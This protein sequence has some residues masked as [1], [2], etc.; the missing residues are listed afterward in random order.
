MWQEVLLPV[1]PLR[2]YAGYRSAGT[3]IQYSLSYMSE[4]Y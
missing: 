1:L 4:L 2:L 3:D